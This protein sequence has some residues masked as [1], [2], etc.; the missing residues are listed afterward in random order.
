MLHFGI[1]QCIRENNSYLLQKCKRYF[2]LPLFNAEV[3]TGKPLLWFKTRTIQMS[4]RPATIKGQM[5]TNS[6]YIE[7]SFN[8]DKDHYLCYQ[9]TRAIEVIT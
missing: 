2:K 3:K 7:L 4:I 1:Y 6:S 8:A 5:S 9:W